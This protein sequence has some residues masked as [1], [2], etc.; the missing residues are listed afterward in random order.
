MVA[1]VIFLRENVEDCGQNGEGKTG[2]IGFGGGDGL[3]EV[4]ADFWQEDV[5]V[6]GLADKVD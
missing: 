4:V 6:G 3:R 2:A 5:R 1:D